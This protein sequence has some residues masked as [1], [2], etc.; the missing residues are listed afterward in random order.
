MFN[1]LDEIGKDC[2]FAGLNRIQEAEVCDATK[3]K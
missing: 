2:F 3:A 1:P